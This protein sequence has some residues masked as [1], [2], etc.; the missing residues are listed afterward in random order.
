MQEFGAFALKLHHEVTASLGLPEHAAEAAGAIGGEGSLGLESAAM[1][2][3]VG[4]LISS[5]LDSPGFWAAFGNSLLMIIGALPTPP[6]KGDGGLIGC[7]YASAPVMSFALGLL[8]RLSRILLSTPLR[9]SHR[10]WRQDIFHRCGAGDAARPVGVRGRNITSSSIAPYIAS[11]ALP[12]QHDLVN[13][14]S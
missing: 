12:R 11:L 1:A 7:P 3:S 13:T 4:S 10:D 5:K 6:L 9:G 14:S 8:L 2:G